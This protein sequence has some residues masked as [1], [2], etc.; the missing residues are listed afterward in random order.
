MMVVG[1]FK[2]AQARRGDHYLM[3][4]FE[5]D[6]CIFFKLRKWLPISGNSQD[7]LLLGCIRRVALDS[8]WSRARSTVERHAGKIDQCLELSKTVGL[9]NPYLE[10]GPLPPYDHFGYEVAIQMV[11]QSRAPGMYSSSYQ[12]WDTIRKNRS[13]FSNQVRA[14][15][16]ANATASSIS[17]LD[18]KNYQQIGKDSC[19]SDSWLDASDGWAKIGDP[20]KLSVTNKCLIY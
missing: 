3:V 19:F 13:C 11:L 7:Q 2:F 15:S 16:V 8:F 14:S 5:C 10:P 20:T 4:Q 9:S 12:Q 1:R 6:G 18:G 17:D